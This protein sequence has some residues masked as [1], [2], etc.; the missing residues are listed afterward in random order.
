M[1][2]L[3]EPDE[4]GPHPDAVTWAV[5]DPAQYEKYLEGLNFRAADETW[6]ADAKLAEAENSLAIQTLLILRADEM[7][8]QALK[9]KVKVEVAPG[10][11][12]HGF[13]TSICPKEFSERVLDA[14]LADSIEL[15]FEKLDA[16]DHWGAQRVRWSMR[17][18][19]LWA[20]FGG[21][22][23]GAFSMFRREKKS[24]D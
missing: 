12:L 15:Y 14:L 18:W 11:K 23:T 2:D 17:G 24:S 8:D 5:T 7:W 21:A 19:M 22:I 13:L 10:F 1:H 4:F 9:P 3:K 6:Q 20:V 16:G